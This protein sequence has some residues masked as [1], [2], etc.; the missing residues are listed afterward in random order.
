MSPADQLRA[1]P[2]AI[3][4]LHV[5]ELKAVGDERGVV[6]EFFRASA[7]NDLG[8]GAIGVWRQVNLTTSRQGVVRGLHGEAMTKL[9]SV[10]V[11]SARGAYVDARPGSASYGRTVTVEL[12]PGRAVLVP[13]GVC[14]GFQAT[15]EGET[16]YLYCFDDEWRPDMAGVAVSAFDPDL[17]IAWPIPVDVN[18]RRLVSAKDAALPRLRDLP[19]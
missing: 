18:D 4:G 14:N 7:V 3:D 13:R 9:V 2:S 6:R 5:L 1:E 8:L 17:G 15:A 12:E 16:A 10:A 11:G 19:G